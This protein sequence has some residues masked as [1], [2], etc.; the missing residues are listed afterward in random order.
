MGAGVEDGGCE[1]ASALGEGFGGLAVAAGDALE[2]CEQPVERPVSF[3]VEDELGEWCVE[4][5]WQLVG[6]RGGDFGE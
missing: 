4:I 3:V 6:D 5:G 2:G 1:D